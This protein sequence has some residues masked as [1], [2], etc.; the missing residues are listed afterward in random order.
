[1]TTSYTILHIRY[2]HVNI[3]KLSLTLLFVFFVGFIIDSYFTFVAG[4]LKFPERL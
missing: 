3:V 1:M 2:T 4:G